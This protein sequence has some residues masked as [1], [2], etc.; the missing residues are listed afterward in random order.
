MLNLLR[1]GRPLLT[2]REACLAEWRRF[3]PEASQLDAASRWPELA[4]LLARVGYQ[5]DLSLYY[6]GRAAEGIGARAAAITYYRESVQLSGT[7]IAC[8]N[9]S[10]VCGGVVLPRAASVRAAALERELARLRYRRAEP[11]PAG[12]APGAPPEE[13]AEP[14]AMSAPAPI[15]APAPMPGP[16]RPP[17]SEF[18]EPPP[19]P[20]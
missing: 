11:P 1:A 5:D 16:P 13:I 19:A 7:A 10:R 17:A 2:C 12:E 4:Q 20:R 9:L 6:L 15:P 14:A 18:I 8:Q 3:Q